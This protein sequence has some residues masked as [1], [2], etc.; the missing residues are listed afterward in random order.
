MKVPLVGCDKAKKL[1]QCWCDG[2]NITSAHEVAAICDR[3][4]DT[5]GTAGR[6]GKHTERWAHPHSQ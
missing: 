4:S 2:V 1:E 3:L 5:V 6:T